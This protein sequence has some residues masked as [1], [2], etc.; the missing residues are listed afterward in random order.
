VNQVS[1][2]IAALMAVLAE[3]REAIRQLDTSAIVKAAGAKETL[4]KRMSAM[5]P[6]QLRPAAADL[7]TLRAEL[8]RNGVLLAHA[9]A[10]VGRAIDVIAPRESNGRRGRLRARV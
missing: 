7:M 4:A 2:T 5:S 8:R 10:C 9:R 1:E 3:E 6:E